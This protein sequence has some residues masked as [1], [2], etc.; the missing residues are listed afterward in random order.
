MSLKLI[1][2]CIF[3]PGIKW[4]CVSCYGRCSGFLCLFHYPRLLGV[5]TSK[6]I[7]FSSIL[8]SVV[9]LNFGGHPFVY[10]GSDSLWNK[11]LS[12][13]LWVGLFWNHIAFSVSL[14]GWN[15]SSGQAQQEYNFQSCVRQDRKFSHLVSLYWN[16]CLKFI[17]WCYP[18]YDAEWD[19]I[20]GE[21]NSF[22]RNLSNKTNSICLEVLSINWV[23]LIFLEF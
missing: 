22:N 13:V 9:L 10:L 21:G 14:Y 8:F 6:Y 3:S 11:N 4:F 20:Q 19:I 23:I 7:F 1:D 12:W 16:N 18:V 5:P 2:W 17:L 15:G